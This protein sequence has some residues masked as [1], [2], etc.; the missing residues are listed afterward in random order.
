MATMLKGARVEAIDLKRNADSGDYKIFS[1]EYALISSS[2]VVL[3][4]QTIGGYGGMVL[5]PSPDT[6]KA[7]REFVRLYQAD[8]TRT[9][10][11]EE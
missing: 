5:E 7:L 11:L 9:L 1:S 6:V 3:A 4:K 8:V 2:D 10:G